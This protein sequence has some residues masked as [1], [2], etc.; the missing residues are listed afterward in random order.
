MHRTNRALAAVAAVSAGLLL[1]GTSMA[2]DAPKIKVGPGLSIKSA[3]GSQSV[4]LTGRLHW[5][6]GLYSGAPTVYEEDLGTGANLRRG[7]LGVKGKNGDMSFNLTIDVG[8]SADDNN[9]AEIDEA[10]IYY[11]PSRNLKLGFG[12]MKI[13][14]TFEESV[15][16][17]DISFIERSL[18]VDMFTDK[19]LGP[20]AVNG[21]LWYYGSQ[22][23][24]EAAYHFMG[25]TATEGENTDEDTG[26]TLR[27]AAA[28]VQADN[29]VV[30]IGGW[31]DRSE[32][33]VSG[34]A[35]WGY[36]P[37]LNVSDA[38]LLYGGKVGPVDS[39]T[40]YGLEFAARFNSFWFQGEYIS[41]EMD[42]EAEGAASVEAAGWYLQAGYV[43]NG[44]KQY[45][46]KK[47]AWKAPKVGDSSVMEVALR[48]SLTDMGDY[49]DV[50]GHGGKQTNLTLGLNWHLNSNSRIMLN[51]IQVDLDEAYGAQDDVT[52]KFWI[53]GVRYQYKF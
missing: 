45:D 17:N 12:K 38:K 11:S 48:Y 46:M 40:H 24:V 42:P 14:V 41:G 47:G 8:G 2:Q 37:E 9:E 6:L 53:Y 10:A 7:R 32:G 16:S 20:K 25:D 29:A 21:Q 1:G 51:A 4:A 26:F 23:L 39:M 44:A 3:D 50:R 28:P 27:L 13:P 19:T 33:P 35:R 43:I 22:F 36:R 30:H 15:S 49:D 18:P 5:D 34:D 31:Y 52:E